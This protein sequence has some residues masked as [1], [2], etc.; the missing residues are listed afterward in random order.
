MRKNILFWLIFIIFM[1]VVEG[2]I[3]NIEQYNF[4]V[5]LIVEP[6]C[7]ELQDKIFHIERQEYISGINFTNINYT[8]ICNNKTTNITKNI[9]KYSESKTGQCTFLES[10]NYTISFN[11]LNQTFL[12]NKTVQCDEEESIEII[13]PV[14]FD[15]TELRLNQEIFEKGEQIE[16]NFWINKIPDYLEITYWIE[17]LNGSIIKNKRTTSNIDT[18]KYT[19]RT[20]TLP[21]EGAYVKAEIKDNCSKQKVQQLI[22]LINEIN[23][24]EKIQQETI[25]EINKVEIIKSNI[26]QTTILA[27][28]GNSRSYVIELI[29]EDEKGKQIGVEKISLKEKNTIVEIKNDWPYKQEKEITILI[30]GLGLEDKKT[31]ILTQNPTIKLIQTHT[32]QKY[33]TNNI[34]WYVRTKQQEP[35]FIEIKSN[36]ITTSKIITYEGEKTTKFEI[37]Y[38][39]GEIYTS[40]F[41]GFEYI[42]KTDKPDILKQIKKEEEKGVASITA[43]ATIEEKEKE[44]TTIGFTGKKEE[45]KTFRIDRKALYGLFGVVLAGSTY[46]LLKEQ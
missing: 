45:T 25:L 17:S 41:N 19:F 18:K 37:P 28:R 30:K 5:D 26:I 23:E 38:N 6:I 8:T 14:C 27:Q 2:E 1:G 21:Q 10:K 31:I 42:N 4:T 39:G 36:N 22:L 40:I 15:K 35:I 29:I 34:T 11:Y 44:N 32:K 7:G 20:I 24:T 3:I 16:M 13:K 9:K 12:W 46:L 33:F 43:F